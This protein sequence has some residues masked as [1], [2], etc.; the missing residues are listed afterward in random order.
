MYRLRGWRGQIGEGRDVAMKLTVDFDHPYFEE[1]E[2]LS[3]M[4]RDLDDYY[5][6]AGE[7]DQLNLYFVLEASLYRLQ[8]RK[9][10]VAA[11]HCAFLLAYYVFVALT[12]PAA[13]EL[14]NAYIDKAL[15][16]NETQEY[17]AWKTWM[18]QGQP[19]CSSKD[20]PSGDTTR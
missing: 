5:A 13:E 18:E 1:K 17:Q 6:E 16:W 2:I 10:S 8:K 7:I 11:A 9:R 14:A 19:L 12:P 4:P 15:A 3:I 20:E